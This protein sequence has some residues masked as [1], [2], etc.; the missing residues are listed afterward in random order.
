MTPINLTLHRLTKAVTDTKGFR[1]IPLN[2]P[3][4]V[5]TVH[6]CE[7]AMPY[8][9]WKSYCDWRMSNI[10]PELESMTAEDR[11]KDLLKFF[12]KV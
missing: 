10:R 7:N 5:K 1:G 3:L 9:I 6:E 4:T 12:G 8:N 11:A 2:T